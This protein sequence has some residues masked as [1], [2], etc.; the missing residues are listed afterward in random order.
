MPIGT[1][2]RVPRSNGSG[3]LTRRVL[4]DHVADAI[5]RYLADEGM[6]PGA[7]MPPVTHLAQQF[8]ASRAVVREALEKLAESG[9]IERDRG[10]RWLVATQPRRGRQRAATPA[11]VPHRSLADQAADAVLELVLDQQLA[12]GDPLPPS[13]ELAQR[14]GVSLIVMREALASLAA[15]GI[16]NRRQGR[17]SVVALPDHE[18]VSSIVR[19]RAHLS[20]ISVDDFQTAR[21]ALEIKAA[22]L[23][24]ANP[25]ATAR[26]GLLGPLGRLRAAKSEVEFNQ[27][28]L[29]FHMTIARLS[30]NKAIELLLASL[31]DTIT[32]MLDVSY[33]RVR[34]RAGEKGIEI[35]VR[36]HERI[37]KAIVAGDSEA[38]AKAMEHHFA[39]AG[40]NPVGAGGRGNR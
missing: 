8:Q 20:A 30:E 39:Y 7:V 26:E 37:A 40:A 32:E 33:R 4:A 1:L 17:E 35:A 18:I 28:D 11:P 5:Q 23:A 15:R 12:E 27:H 34:S 2:A 6:R 9:A 29:A 10:R 19:V 24:A 13:G 38:A 36:N 22:A 21:A 16:L 31:H 14:L 3:E 25:D